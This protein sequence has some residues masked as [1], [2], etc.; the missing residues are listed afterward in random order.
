MILIFTYPFHTSRS[1]LSRFKSTGL[2]SEFSFSKSGY[3]TKA[4]EPRLPHYLPLVGR[5]IVKFIPFPRVSVLCQTEIASFRIRTR[6][7]VSISFDGDH[8]TASNY[9]MYKFVCVCVCVC[10]L[11]LSGKSDVKLAGFISQLETSYVSNHTEESWY[12]ETVCL[13]MNIYIYIYIYIYIS[14]V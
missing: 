9:Q 10:R 8:Y 11:M 1:I 13:R 7:T 5:R 4:K 2:N 6:V 3:Y 14:D 12:N